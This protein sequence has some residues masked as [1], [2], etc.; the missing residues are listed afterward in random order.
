MKFGTLVE[1]PK[2]YTKVSYTPALEET[3]SRPCWIERAILTM[4][5]LILAPVLIKLL[6]EVLTD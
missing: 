2:T 3:G 5:W 6:V 4:F 1:L